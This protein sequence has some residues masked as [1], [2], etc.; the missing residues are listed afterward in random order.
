[1]PFD[2]KEYMKKYTQTEKSKKFYRIRHWRERGLTDDF[3]KVYQLYLDTTNCMK[4]SI[5]L[6]ECKKNSPAKKCMDHDHDT[7][8]YRA[9]LCNSCNVSNLDDRHAQPNNK[10]GIKNIVFSSSGYR[11]QKMKNYKLHYSIW[12][13]TIEEAIKYKDEYL[14]N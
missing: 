14:K 10:V 11:F 9:I 1:M 13:K 2:K 8:L 4:C 6:I 7:G 12:F 5:E 3:E